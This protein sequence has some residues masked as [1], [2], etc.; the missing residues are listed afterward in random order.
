[1]TNQYKIIENPYWEESFNKPVE[2]SITDLLTDRTK[3]YSLDIIEAP[4]E[5]HSGLIKVMSELPL[6]LQFAFNQGPTNF[7]YIV[8]LNSPEKVRTGKGPTY[9]LDNAFDEREFYV[10]PEGMTHV[11][12]QREKAEDNLLFLGNADEVI[13]E[14]KNLGY[15]FLDRPFEYRQERFERIRE[16]SKH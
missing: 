14:F 7:R 9:V 15:I 4:I 10:L 1:M 16:L 5:E 8:L 2:R 11:W 12:G 3:G 6:D 13:E